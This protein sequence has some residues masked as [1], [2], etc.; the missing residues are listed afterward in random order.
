MQSIPLRDESVLQYHPGFLSAEAA[1]ELFETLR[2]DKENSQIPWA[3]GSVVMRG[4][5]VKEPRFSVFLG[6]RDGIVYTY[7]EKKNVSTKW[8][9]CV[10][11]VKVTLEKMCGHPFN[12]CLVNWYKDGTQHINWHSDSE[13]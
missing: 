13:V 10:E 5:Q 2:Y 6:E 3:H 8:P 9:K 4:V 1:A 7:S 12:A 11:A